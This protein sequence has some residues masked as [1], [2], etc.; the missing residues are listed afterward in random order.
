MEADE[1]G[2]EDQDDNDNIDDE[3]II[4]D[5]LF[6]HVVEDEDGVQLVVKLEDVAVDFDEWFEEIPPDETILL[7]DK[8]PLS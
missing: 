1:E 3:E 4:H 7:V 8:V 6:L 5:E 2:Y